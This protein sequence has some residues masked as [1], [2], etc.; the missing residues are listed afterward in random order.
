MGPPW[1]TT[2]HRRAEIDGQWMVVVFA[3]LVACE[4]F[5]GWRGVAAASV[6]A[7]ATLAV[8]LPISAL[9]RLLGV[10]R[11]REAMAHIFGMGLLLGLATPLTTSLSV[12]F[13]AGAV[14]GLLMHGMG[15]SHRLRIHPVAVALLLFWMTPSLLEH[16]PSLGVDPQ[17]VRPM[18][19]VLI[20]TRLG[21]GDALD[22]AEKSSLPWFRQYERGG[23][24]AERRVH[25]GANLIAARHELLKNRH[26]LVDALNAGR[27][28]RLEEIFLGASPDATGGA[29][30]FLLIAMGFYLMYRRHL[31]WIDAFWSLPAF[32]LTLLMMPIPVATITSVGQVTPEGWT[33]LIAPLMQI[34]PAA[35]ITY[36]VYFIFATPMT[37]IVMILAPMTAPMCAN[38]RLV[39]GL[40]IGVLGLLLMWWFQ[41]PHAAYGA[42]ILAGLLSRPLD[43]LQKSP[44]V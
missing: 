20:P 12:H 31:K 25:T 8:H 10:R 43:A 16:L 34:G 32:V 18:Q 24:D 7:L 5:V 13:A 26:A 38:G 36:L 27:L 17:R 29:S 37:L 40:I 41:S 11:P 33:L 9:F 39:Y 3:M 28:A 4:V 44:F 35:A 19:S 30:R 6:T 22:A 21:V 15:R 2:A 42:L 23:P 1:I 14:L